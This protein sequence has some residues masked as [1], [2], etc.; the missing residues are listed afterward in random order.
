M[1]TYTWIVLIVTII[2][3]ILLIALLLRENQKSSLEITG[4][5]RGNKSRSF[6]SAQ[7]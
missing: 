7:N 1:D 3:S 6:E 5:E 4:T 2:S